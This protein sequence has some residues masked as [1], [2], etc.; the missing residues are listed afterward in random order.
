MLFRSGGKLD[1]LPIDAYVER[2]LQRNNFLIASHNPL[3]E[4][5]IKQMGSSERDRASFIRNTLD[6]AVAALGGG[7]R[8]RTDTVGVN[9]F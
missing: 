5:L 9:P 2:L 6:T 3:R 7:A 1:A 8:W 4:T